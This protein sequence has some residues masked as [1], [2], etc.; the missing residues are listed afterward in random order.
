MIFRAIK[1]KKSKTGCGQ[2]NVGRP[3]RCVMAIVG[4]VLAVCAMGAMGACDAREQVLSDDFFAYASKGEPFTFGAFEQDADANNGKEPLE[5]IVMANDSGTVLAI[6]KYVLSMRSY[7]SSEDP[8]QATWET[9]TLRTWLNGDFYDEAF[10]DDEKALICR[11][12]LEN[13]DGILY[14]TPGGEN[15]VDNVFIPSDDDVAAYIEDRGFSDASYVKYKAMALTRFLNENPSKESLMYTTSTASASKVTFDI[16]QVE[17]SDEDKALL[18]Q[19]YDATTLPTAWW[20]RTPGEEPGTAMLV[21]SLQGSASYGNVQDQHGV[22]PA[23]VLAKDAAFGRSDEANAEPDGV[24]DGTSS[25]EFERDDAG[26][27]QIN[28]SD[29]NV[30]SI[31][32]D[33]T[34]ECAS[35]WTD[36]PEWPAMA[37]TIAGD[38]IIVGLTEEGKVLVFAE[39][40]NPYLVDTLPLEGIVDIAICDEARSSSNQANTGCILAL[41]DTDTLYASMVGGYGWKEDGIVS[42]AAS[43]DKYAA[44]RAD[45]TVSYAQF[46]SGDYSDVDTWQDIVQIACGDDFIAGL[47]RDGSVVVAGGCLPASLKKAPVRVTSNALGNRSIEFDTSDWD[48][49]VAIAAGSNH[50]VGLMRDGS[51]LADGLN[52]YG[53]TD[54]ADWRGVTRIDASEN[55]TV[56]FLDDGSVIVA[57]KDTRDTHRQLAGTFDRLYEDYF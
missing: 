47:K 53:Q 55:A 6:S 39:G 8:Q 57:G 49:V 35:F 30:L 44:V 22:R 46:E 9:S 15:T 3:I 13:R 2:G 7:D 14:R 54:V 43:D 17:M 31:A 40:E 20:L 21:A 56:G 5:W 12:N 48:D 25:A 27:R 34:A 4:V 18:E 24:V 32:E 38:G 26:M 11:L 51:V 37:K 33:G 28:F 50:L 29:G 16:S 36:G 23:I 10:S 42:I 52:T 1:S 45:G 41:S 19:Y